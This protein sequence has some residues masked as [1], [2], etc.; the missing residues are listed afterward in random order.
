M[1]G[2]EQGQNSNSAGVVFQLIA[3]HYRLA[4]R[5]ALA[6]SVVVAVLGSVYV[7]WGQPVRRTFTLE[8]R[9]TFTGAETGQYPNGI[10]FTVSEVADASILDMVY[11]TNE[12]LQYCGREIF[13]GGFYVEQRSTQ[14]LSLDAE[15]QGRLS[16]PRISPIERQR[17]QDEYQ[18]KRESLPM[19]FRLVFIQPQACSEIPRVVVTKAMTD[20]LTTWA[21]ESDLKRGVLNHDVE[22]LTPGML[23][24]I[25]EGSSLLRADLLRTSLWRVIYNI[26][27][28]A[29]L[30]GAN[31]VRLPIPAATS[32]ADADAGQ[33]NEQVSFMEIRHKLT[34]L[35]RSTL[36]PLV[37]GAGQSLVRESMA[38]V[39]ETV[40]NAER[41]K[42]AAEGRAAAY[43]EALREYSGTAQTAKT[44]SSSAAQSPTTSRDVQTISPQIDLT[45]IDRI[46]EMSEANIE[47]RRELTS[48]MVKATLDSV[49]AEERM[50]Y[51][52]RLLASLKQPSER[53]MTPEEIDASL[54]AIIE[55][56]KFLTQ[57]YNDLYLEF[58]R[59]SLRSAAAL[60]EVE[61]PVTSET[62]RPMSLSSLALMVLATFVAALLLA[63]VF[64]TLQAE[65]RAAESKAAPQP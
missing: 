5:I 15:Y 36:E 43:L 18:S 60:Y 3:R 19:Q 55:R 16:D 31:L 54:K 42:E 63:F 12:I 2:N 58:S 52:K 7:F 50:G 47:Y 56:G 27:E 29:E 32:P 65:V 34:D 17:L 13:R 46:V 57:Q 4:V 22:V 30:P 8:F 45:F 35:V 51:Y 49:A 59:V 20:V 14:S 26:D 6:V 33:G 64:L 53:F 41:T 1:A 10:P 24:S 40:N 48:A 44:P 38:W 62:L 25:L 39:T 61:R 21:K 9:P 11:D 37:V 23:D 28:V